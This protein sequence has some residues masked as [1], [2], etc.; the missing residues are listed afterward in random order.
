MKKGGQFQLSFSMIFSIILIISIIAIAAYV[1]INFLSL[2]KCTK[3]GLFYDGLKEKINDAWTSTIYR[4]VFTG[5]LPS[6]IE[7]VC[8]GDLGGGYSGEYGKQF[9]Y[10]SEYVGAGNNVFLYPLQD[11]CDKRLSYLKLEKIEITGFF[12][13]RVENGKVEIRINKGQFD[14]KVAVSE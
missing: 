8:F 4:D 1:T 3:V 12:C 2:G 14:S 10:L 11:S 7:Y 9:D 5:E 13:A 6:E